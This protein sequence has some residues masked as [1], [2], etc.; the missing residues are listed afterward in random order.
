M[1]KSIKLKNFNFFYYVTQKPSLDL[2][3]E[4]HHS[5]YEILYVRNGDGVYIVEDKEYLIWENSIFIIPPGKYHTFKKSPCVA[6]E[7]Y[8]INFDPNIL[9]QNLR[10]DLIIYKK[11]TKVCSELFQKI[12]EYL[13]HYP[14]DISE[15]LTESLIKEIFITTSF[16][17]DG[18][19]LTS[20]NTPDIVQKAIFYI[21]NNLDKPITIESLANELFISPSR[22]THAFQKT[23]HT[24]IITYAR[25][26]KMYK[27]Q[28]LIKSGLPLGEVAFSLGYTD[29][30][31]FF[32]T[33][34]SFFAHSPSQYN[35]RKE[36]QN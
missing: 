30:P 13:D 3:K 9:P 17:E 31:T 33:Y 35:K 27:A 32:K 15:I 28:E 21:T 23:M 10:H 2:F 11:A 7:R 12:D 29:Y 36:G 20:T 5:D 6:Y 25:I 34:K 1:G 26:K 8:V 19:A 14:F 4:H 22:L 18:E 24:G 16:G